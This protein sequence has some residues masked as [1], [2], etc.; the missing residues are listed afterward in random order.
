[1]LPYITCL[2]P[3]YKRPHLLQTAV[4]CFEMQDYP[5][6]R[7]SL[8]VLDDAGQ[9]GPDATRPREN[10]RIYSETDRYENLP[11]KFN[12]IVSRA[13]KETEIFVVW[14]DDDIYLPHHLRRVGELHLL[15]HTPHFH[16]E[17][18]YTTYGVKHGTVQRERAAGRFHASWAFTKG[19]F[20]K[21]GGYPVSNDLS[22]DAQLLHKLTEGQG[23]VCRYR[24]AP[25]GPS[26]VYRWGN[27]VY[28]GS[29]A[30]LAH[31]STLWAELATRPVEH[32]A[33][34]TPVLDSQAVAIL[35]FV[36]QY[37]WEQIQLA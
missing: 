5:K 36:E 25:L 19:L 8:V 15:G 23:G 37:G 13:P 4:K 7:C 22:F 34:F 21:I 9:Y 17:Q 31:Y 20:E 32:Q 14:E 10:W 33:D 30:G 3:T 16:P 29:Q 24:V 12:E 28:H 6:D 35:A 27:G 18:I 11:T 26:Y 1:M 2:C